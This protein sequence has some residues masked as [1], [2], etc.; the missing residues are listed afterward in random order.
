MS[1]DAAALPAESLPLHRPNGLEETTAARAA[2]TSPLASSAQG[3]VTLEGA[4]IWGKE[5]SGEV[6]SDVLPAEASPYGPTTC[7]KKSQGNRPGCSTTPHGT[8]SASRTTG[9]GCPKR[10]GTGITRPYAEAGTDAAQPPST[11]FS[12]P[13][14]DGGEQ[15]S[16]KREELPKR[17]CPGMSPS[18]QESCGWG[19]WTPLD[20]RAE[21]SALKAVLC[22]MLDQLS[23]D[24]AAMCRDVSS[25]QGH[26]GRLERDARDWALNVAALQKGDRSLRETIRQ[27]KSHCRRLENQ[28]QH[29]SLHLVGLPEG[30]EGGDPIAFLQKALPTLLNLPMDSPPLEIESAHCM[31][32]GARWHPATPPQALAFRL[33]RFSDKLAILHAARKRVA[34]LTWGGAHVAIFPAAC[35]R[36]CRRRRTQHAAIQ[37]LWQGQSSAWALS[38][39]AAARAGPESTGS[40][41][42]APRDALLLQ[43]SRRAES[44]QGSKRRGQLSSTHPESQG[45]SPF[46]PG[47]HSILLLSGSAPNLAGPGSLFL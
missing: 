13:G 30:A 19:S 35:A 8:T 36:L 18:A 20:L 21:L 32:R 15:A 24:L 16:A 12:T 3:A 4:E 33:L 5:L 22:K 43:M 28:A 2:P 37:Q 10:P 39:L 11:A 41:C 45:P 42:P 6:K 25:V 23:Q 31:H 26:V 29:N 14:D 44:P 1:R 40:H 38:S 46:C 27:L 47:V 17:Q 7:Q 34:P 9:H